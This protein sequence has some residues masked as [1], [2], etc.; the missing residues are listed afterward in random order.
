MIFFCFGVFKI[1][2]LC[3]WRYHAQDNKEIYRRGKFL[4]PQIRSEITKFCKGNSKDKMPA[5]WRLS[6]SLSR[7]WMW[8]SDPAAHSSHNASANHCFQEGRGPSWSPHMVH[9]HCDDC[10]FELAVTLT[11]LFFCVRSCLWSILWKQSALRLGNNVITT[12][13]LSIEPSACIDCAPH[14]PKNTHACTK[15]TA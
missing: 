5:Q 7:E 4:V 9:S 12:A 1:K 11:V 2:C 3:Y 8:W 6:W 14:T 10:G 13:C 15:V